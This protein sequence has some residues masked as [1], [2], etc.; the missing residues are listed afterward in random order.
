M[1]WNVT[2]LPGWLRWT[3]VT[4]WGSDL[5]AYKICIIVVVSSFIFFIIWH[6]KKTN[7][8]L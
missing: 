5:S 4:A 3:R 1:F 8:G 7:E 2:N 6:A